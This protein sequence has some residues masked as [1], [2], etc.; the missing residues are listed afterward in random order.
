M[1]CRS[2]NQRIQGFIG[3]KIVCVFLFIFLFQNL[4]A[5]VSGLILFNSKKGDTTAF[6]LIVPGDKIKVEFVDSVQKVAKRD[7]VVTALNDLSL[8][9]DSG[10]VITYASV[11]SIGYLRDIEGRHVCRTIAIIS[12]VG[13]VVSVAFLAHELF[14]GDLN[15]TLQTP[16]V[17]AIMTAA[18]TVPV[19]ILFATLAR[20]EFRMYQ[21]D[22]NTRFSFVTGNDFLRMRR[23]QFLKDAGVEIQKGSGSF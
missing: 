17:R 1:A 21:F 5:Q 11:Q 6:H 15:G 18:V 12:S 23:K 10:H 22:R 16:A 20:K 19:T 9:L 13:A 14:T 7:G 3:L 8:T 4:H 2:D